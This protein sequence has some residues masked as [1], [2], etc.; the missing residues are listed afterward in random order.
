MIKKLREAGHTE[1]T[2]RFKRLIRAQAIREYLAAKEDRTL[3]LEVNLAE[4][5][6]INRMSRANKVMII[7]DDVGE[8]GDSKKGGRN[9]FAVV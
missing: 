4:E 7:P 1:L 9:P 2:L 8:E 5:E 3:S 6:I